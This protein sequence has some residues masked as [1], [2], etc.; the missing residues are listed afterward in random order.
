MSKT[1]IIQ[2]PNRLKKAKIGTGPV[3]LDTKAI[4]RA[5]QAIKDMQQDYAVWAQEDL[6]ALEAAFRR[7]CAGP[8]EQSAEL[9][10]MFRI[11]LDMKG[12][13]ASFGYPLITAIGDSLAAFVEKRSSLVGL[14]CDVIAAHIATMRAVFAGNVRGDGG[15]TGR[16]LVAGLQALI[17][18]AVTRGHPSTAASARTR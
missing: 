15:A 5:E 16:E 9:R 18:K 12:Q 6:S 7:A 17:D 14:D 13:G 8:A 11:A 2:P 3:K 10:V 4:E 1:E